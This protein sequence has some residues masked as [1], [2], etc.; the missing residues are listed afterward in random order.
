M[1]KTL[2]FLIITAV[3]TLSSINSYAQEIYSK[4][5]GE[6]SDPA[7]LFMHGGPG[8]NSVSFELSTAQLLA[9]KGFY[10]IVFDQ[11]GGGRSKELKGSYFNFK[12]AFED[13]N[14]IL[15]KHG[16]KKASIMG[17]SW[18]G[19]LGLH[20]AMKY[21]NKV[22]K[23]IIVDSPLSYQESFKV[24][25]RRCKEKYTAEKSPN[26]Q[27]INMLEVMDTTKLEYA[28]YCFMNA[29]QAG[30]YQPKN[31]SPESKKIFQEV[32]KMPDANLISDMTREPVMGFYT[33]ENYTM[34]DMTSMIKK[35]AMKNKIYGIYGAEDGLFDEAQYSKFEELMG[36]DN[37]SII[38]D[39][40]H[41]VFIDQREK[42]IDLVVWYMSG[43]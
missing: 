6:K 39:A 32:M 41:S 16:V 15:K 26:L 3:F 14:N 28:T 34:L 40:S 31:Q 21:P 17:H 13:I 43:E 10:V 42:F 9:D 37:F 33:N 12:E 5:Y 30:L 19:T 38:Q 2:L 23:F 18:G 29:M 8:Y 36:E 35:L 11:R 7:I 1:T 25:I 22:E 27:Y 4:A 24:I 20:Y